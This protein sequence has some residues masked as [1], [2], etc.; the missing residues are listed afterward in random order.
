M[1]PSEVLMLIVEASLG[2]A[3]F[4]GVVTAVG[5]RSVTDLVELQRLNLVNLLATAF[6]AL[7][8]SLGALALQSAQVDDATIWR[9]WSAVGIVPMLFF[10]VRSMLTVGRSIGLAQAARSPTL[11]TI[12]TLGLLTC[13]LQIWNVSSAGFFWPFFVLLITLFALGCFS[14]ARL[15]LYLRA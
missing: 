4:A 8:M 3:G 15:L 14:F 12:N 1:N 13:G 11:L 10:G 2:L 5:Q 6:G 9:I 7:F